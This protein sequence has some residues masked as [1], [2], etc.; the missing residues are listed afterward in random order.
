MISLSNLRDKMTKLRNRLLINEITKLYGYNHYRGHALLSALLKCVPQLYAALSFLL[1]NVS[2]NYESVGGGQWANYNIGPHES[3]D[4]HKYLTSSTA[5]G[6]NGIVP[7]GFQDKELKVQKGSDLVEA[8]KGAITRDGKSKPVKGKEPQGLLNHF[9]NVLVTTLN[10]PWQ[11]VNTGNALLLLRAF[12]EIVLE[13]VDQ[14]NGGEPK[15]ALDEDI[16]PRK[17]CWRDL[18]KHF[19]GS[20]VPFS[21]VFNDGGFGFIGQ[22]STI[23]KKKEFA[24]AFSKWFRAN[25]QHIKNNLLKMSGRIDH[26]DIHSFAKTR[27]YP[28]GLI[29]KYGGTNQWARTLETHWDSVI[30]MFHAKGHELE[31]LK[32][33]LEGKHTIL[34]RETK[35]S[36]TRA[37]KPKTPQLPP[38]KVPEVPKKPVPPKKSEGAQNRSKKADG[39]PNHN[40]A[41]SVQHHPGKVGK[42]SPDPK[43]TGGKGEV[44]PHGPLPEKGSLGHKLPVVP[45]PSPVQVPKGQN[46]TQHQ[47]NGIQV[48]SVIS[49]PGSPPSVRGVP[50]LAGAPSVSSKGPPTNIPTQQPSLPVQTALT[51]SPTVSRSDSGSSGASYP[52]SGQG[53]DVESSPSPTLLATQATT[54]A[55]EA[56]SGAATSAAVPSI[57]STDDEAIGGQLGSQGSPSKNPV[58][59]MSPGDK[60]VVGPAVLEP[61]PGSV[62]ESLPPPVQPQPPFPPSLSSYSSSSLHNLKHPSPTDG[63]REQRQP[64][65]PARPPSSDPNASRSGG[66]PGEQGLN[67]SVGVG[68]PRDDL[69][70]EIPK[71][72]PDPLPTQVTSVR[73]SEGES[74]SV[75]GSIGGSGD[76]DGLPKN[77]TQGEVTSSTSHVPSVDHTGHASQSPKTQS[78]QSI[79]ISTPQNIHASNTGHGADSGLTTLTPNVPST[80]SN[81]SAFAG[82]GGMGDAS[83]THSHSEK[84][85]GGKSAMN[86]GGAK[87]CHHNRM[88][89]A[90]TLYGGQKTPEALWHQH[91]NEE[92][93][94]GHLKPSVYNNPG[95]FGY[96][97]KYPNTYRFRSYP[98]RGAVRGN[99][100]HPPPA[101]IP[102]HI[103]YRHD[104]PLIG[105]EGPDILNQEDPGDEWNRKHITLQQQEFR[106]WNEKIL[107]ELKMKALIQPKTEL[108]KTGI[109]VGRQ[110]K[111]PR[112]Q[113]KSLLLPHAPQLNGQPDSESIPDSSQFADEDVYPS[114]LPNLDVDIQKPSTEGKQDTQVLRNTAPLQSAVIEPQLPTKEIPNELPHLYYPG[115][116]IQNIDEDV[117]EKYVPN[118]SF[119]VMPHIDICR[120]PWHVPNSSPYTTSL[121]S[122]PPSDHLPSPTTVRGILYWL[123]G[124]VAMEYIG[125]LHRHVEDI[126]ENIDKDAGLPYKP[127]YT[128]DIIMSHPPLA[129]SLVTRTMTEACYYAASVLCRLKHIQISDVIKDFDFSSE[130]QKY[131]YSSDPDD[132][133]CQVRDYVYAAHHQVAFLR[134]QCYREDFQGGWKDFKYGSYVNVSNSI[135]QAFLTDDWNSACDTYFFNPCN[136]C[137]KSRVRMGFS[138]VDL[139]KQQQTGSTLLGILSP[140]CDP[141]DPLLT[142]A[143]YLVC[144]TRRTPRTTAEI[145]SFFHHFGN[146]LYEYDPDI[147]SDVGASLLDHPV[148]YFFWAHLEDADLETVRSLRGCDPNNQCHDHYK[149][150]STLIGC[151]IYPI[152]C[153]QLLLPITYATYALYSPNFVDTYLSWMIYLPD[154]LHDSLKRLRRDLRESKCSGIKPLHTCVNAM[155]TL[156]LHGFAPPYDYSK[157]PPNCS[158]VIVKLSSV[159]SGGPVAKLL[160]CA[161]DFLYRAR[162]PFVVLVF[163]LWFVAIICFAHTQ[164]YRLDVLRIRSHIMLSKAS[165]LINVKALLSLS[166]KMP[167]LY[168]VDYFDDEVI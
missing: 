158:D 99:Q 154:R 95:R 22:V 115:E 42:D 20:Q 88:V 5:S 76:C 83:S 3:N 108:P 4:L 119:N 53:R 29:F 74:F 23:T 135:L 106:N 133:L 59:R 14:Q 131:H 162:K 141:Y 17:V 41:Q 35:E 139:P 148:E 134:L 121:I 79:P 124:L 13:E 100:I 36:K 93:K 66:A 30:S 86:F 28:Y 161:D 10:R 144:L 97:S 6:Y 163:T 37:A 73:S 137:L 55:T 90:R 69:S 34:C 75:R 155:S 40:N 12:Q 130:Y 56:N 149:T 116:G 70:H 57:G 136:A 105:Y 101:R 24:D 80:A 94:R 50:G 102:L 114:R 16:K 84:C 126:F 129:A 65:P 51:P 122:P 72:P 63:Q 117:E 112:P 81:S 91:E 166:K 145:V 32:D 38:A 39:T 47:Q 58:E 132:L 78:P 18:R 109:A 62:P 96:P 11:D 143:T 27:L 60:V 68:K 168:R 61:P 15:K 146:V 160:T 45:A 142:L 125:I 147:L 165:H 152:P 110:L 52:D 67:S 103:A 49:P 85:F 64:M 138:D 48:P 113:K 107:N 156:Y 43:I 98:Y 31:R 26:S 153:P 127:S 1:Y 104:F 54:T 159:V 123:V 87:L 89:F 151:D 118:N 46:N 19:A 128:L 7:G 77:A 44:S 82:I 2:D 140:N 164:L 33:I 71:S 157:P 167:S 111:Q 9:T 21:N 120:D 92:E 8:L 25:Y 150:L